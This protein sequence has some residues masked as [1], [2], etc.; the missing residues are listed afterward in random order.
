MDIDSTPLSISIIHDQRLL[1][2]QI[3]LHLLRADL[4]HPQVSGN[5]WF[6]LTYNIAAAREAQKQCLLSFG[7]VWSNHLHA[8]AFAGKQLGLK[9]IGIIRGEDIDNAMLH[10]CRQWGM[11]LHFVSRSE[12]RSKTEADWLRPWQDRFPN[13]WFI[14]EGG[15]N[16]EGCRGIREMLTDIDISS[17][18]R[19]CCPVGTGTTLAGLCQSVSEN[20]FITGFTAMK[21]GQYLTQNIA[22]QTQHQQWALET[23]YSYGGFGRVNKELLCFMKS[24]QEQQGIELDR[25]YTAKMMAGIYDLI[26]RE[27]WKGPSRILAI[28]TGGLQ[29][30]RSIISP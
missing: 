18:Q 9:T 19:V 11:E 13:A 30:N 12:Y 4:L 17:Y 28:H 1:D 6:K 23:E 5:K 15:S 21:Q 22:R 26:L 27:I 3:E 24:F 10:D 29:G 2:R 25:V 16:A 14:P 8:L 7:G 20:I